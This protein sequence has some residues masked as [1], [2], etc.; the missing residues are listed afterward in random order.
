MSSMPKVANEYFK[1]V[2]ELDAARELYFAERA[3]L[4]EDIAETI[5]ASTS[6][7]DK[8][9]GVLQ[10]ELDGEYTTARLAR[11]GKKRTSGYRVLIGHHH[12]FL[13]AQTLV[14]FGLRLTPVREHR[15]EVGPLASETKT[16]VI[17]DGSSFLI[18]T[19]R[20]TPD[21]FDSGLLADQVQRLPAIFARWDKHIASRFWL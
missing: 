4:L 7:I 17:R 11:E 5:A 1:H 8:G 18:R 6:T 13:G 2:V 20:F 3:K 14:W 16:Q 19:S 12:E 10:V 9:G 21:A 15:L